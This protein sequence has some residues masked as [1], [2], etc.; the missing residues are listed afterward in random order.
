MQLLPVRRIEAGVGQLLRDDESLRVG[1]DSLRGGMI[2]RGHHSRVRSVIAF[3]F[4]ILVLVLTSGT[5]STAVRCVVV[6]RVSSS[7]MIAGAV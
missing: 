5:F 1:H 3:R 4:L 6:I 7:M 2:D